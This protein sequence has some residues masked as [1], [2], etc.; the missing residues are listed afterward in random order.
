[1]SRFRLLGNGRSGSAELV[2]IA[3]LLAVVAALALAT[4]AHGRTL[5]WS[6][7]SW[8]RPPAVHPHAPAGNVVLPGG[9]D[10]RRHAAPHPEQP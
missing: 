8:Q 1:L 9:A 2:G 3:G 5:P 7:P 4:V 10:A 6:A